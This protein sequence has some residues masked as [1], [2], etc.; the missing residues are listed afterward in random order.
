MF[1]KKHSSIHNL[2][3]ARKKK[4]K[5]LFPSLKMAKWHINDNDDND[6]D[7]WPTAAGFVGFKE[8][9]IPRLW[10][11]QH[12]STLRR[13]EYS[14]SAKSN[15]HERYYS[16]PFHVR[17]GKSGMFVFRKH[18][19][20]PCAPCMLRSISGGSSLK[21]KSCFCMQSSMPTR[22]P[23]GAVLLY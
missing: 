5:N 12:S 22:L 1:L 7:L 13:W 4:K 15:S 17:T 9:N 6:R 14:E 18:F 10:T 11:R 2:K 19:A 21:G 23:T 20:S 3:K 8:F 16:S